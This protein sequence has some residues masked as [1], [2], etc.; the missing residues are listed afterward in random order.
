MI[1]KEDE[2]YHYERNNPIKALRMLKLS[3]FKRE[4]LDKLS[5]FEEN[6]DLIH[7]HS[8]GNGIT[9]HEELERKINMIMEVEPETKFF[10]SE[11]WKISNYL[12]T[13]LPA[14][15]LSFLLGAIDNEQNEINE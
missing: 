10:G 14:F 15:M 9:T 6:K 2:D 1:T 7:S 11:Q 4:Q 13:V 5:K 8:G 3:N 12:S